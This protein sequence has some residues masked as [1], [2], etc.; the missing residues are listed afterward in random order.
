M[1]TLNGRVGHLEARVAA[2]RGPD[3]CRACGLRHVRPLTMAIVRGLFRIRGGTA[4]PS[5]RTDPLCLCDCCTADPG[6]R[7]FAHL[8]HGLP[9]DG[10]A[11]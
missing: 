4:T 5:P 9:I 8:S 2:A 3:H 10:D 6:D 7:R 11:A 1:P